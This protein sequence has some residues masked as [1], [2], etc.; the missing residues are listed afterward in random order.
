MPQPERNIV[1]RAILNSV[2]RS[3][4][5]QG[6]HLLGMRDELQRFAGASNPCRADTGQPL[7]SYL[8]K[9]HH[10]TYSLRQTATNREGLDDGNSKVANQFKGETRLSRCAACLMWRIRTTF[11]LNLTIINPVVTDIKATYSNPETSSAQP[12]TRPATLSTAVA[13]D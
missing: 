7:R 12:H 2:L 10:S 8:R 5:P 1:H 3:I 4:G 6:L 11:L 13:I 9:D